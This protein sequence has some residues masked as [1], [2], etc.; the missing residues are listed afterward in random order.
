MN[1]HKEDWERTE[2]QKTWAVKD[3]QQWETGI[4]EKYW[5]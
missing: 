4:M 2:W 3:K 5:Q 1:T